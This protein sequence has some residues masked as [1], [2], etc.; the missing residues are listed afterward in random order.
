MIGLAVHGEAGQFGSAQVVAQDVLGIVV[1]PGTGY[2]DGSAL[3]EFA[4]V[5]GLDVGLGGDQLL[6]ALRADETLVG[7]DVVVHGDE[8]AVIVG[9]PFG[10]TAGTEEEG[11]RIP[12]G[13][14]QFHGEVLVG[15]F[16]VGDQVFQGAQMSG[17]DGALVVVHEVAVISG[18]RVGIQIFTHGSS[19]YGTG[20]VRF[21]HDGGSALA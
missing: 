19:R 12:G 1:G 7:V 18:Q 20:I 2:H 9:G 4:Y 5:R 11:D 15:G 3:G 17:V 8:L 6:Q 14:L 13:V 16:A 21:L 10:D